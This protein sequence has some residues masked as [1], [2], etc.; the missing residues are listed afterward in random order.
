[1]PLEQQAIE[2]LKG[3]S[4]A[5]W[6]ARLPAGCKPWRRL[7]R[8]DEANPAHEKYV[9]HIN[10]KRFRFVL[11]VMQGD[12]VGFATNETTAFAPEG[13][14]KGLRQRLLALIRT[15]ISRHRSN[16]F[17]FISSFHPD[18]RRLYE[19]QANHL[20]GLLPDRIVAGH[21][22]YLL[23]KSIEPFPR[24]V[25]SSDPGNTRNG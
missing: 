12:F 14:N 1:M 20:V 2:S 18:T 4:A 23:L 15:R 24:S 10:G 6:R 16:T 25:P 22:D 21:G 8:D 19:R 9:K 3:E 17:L 5:D 13:R 7:E 11:I